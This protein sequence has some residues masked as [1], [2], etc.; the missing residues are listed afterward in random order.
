MPNVISAEKRCVT[1]LENRKVF[2]WMEELARTRKTDL[3]VILREATAAY[4]AQDRSAPREGDL[5][6]Q[7]AAAK[8]AARRKTSREIAAGV[9]TPKQ[10]QDRNAPIRQPVQ[11]VNLW[12][13][14]RRHTRA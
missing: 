6:G 3:A 12:P 11:I 13:A 10:A 1:Y 4:C 5:F 14:I 2:E 9:V 8:A 7:R